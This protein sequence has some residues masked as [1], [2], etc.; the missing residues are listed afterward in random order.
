MIWPFS[1]TIWTSSKELQ[2]KKQKAKNTILIKN[3]SKWINDQ[4]VSRKH[5]KY[6]L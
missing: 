6:M 2:R 1:S 3:K 5:Q 4:G